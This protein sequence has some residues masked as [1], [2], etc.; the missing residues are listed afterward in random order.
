METLHTGTEQQ[1]DVHAHGHGEHHHQETFITKYVFSLDHKTIGKQFLITGMAWAIIGGLMSVI[2]RLQLG[3]PDET[4]PWLERIFSAWYTD[5]KLTPEAYYSLITMHG[6]IMVFFVLTASLSG[7]FANILIPL[8]IGARDMA[9]PLM[10][11]ISY[12]LFFISG[13]IMFASLFLPTGAA[14]A[15]WT[16]YPPLSALPQA[17]PGSGAGM[18]WWLIA[19][20]LFVAST[21]VGG[22]NYVSTVLNLRTKGMT[23]FK[24]PLTVWALFFTAIIGILSFPV[25]VSGVVLLIFDRTLHTSFYLSDIV[26]GGKAMAFAGGSP[27][28]FQHLFWFL[29]HPEV[30]III[31]PAMGMVSE[32]LAVHSRKP[33]FGYKAMIFSILGITILGFIVWAHHMFVAGVNPFLGSIFTLFTLLIAIPSAVKVFNWLTTLWKGNIKITPPLV[34]AVAFVSTFIS[35]G[36]TGIWLGN[37]TIDIQVHA[38]Y[39]VV[40]HF[41]IVMGVSAFFGMFAG[42]YHWYP[43]MFGRLMNETLAY[44]HFAIT[45]IGAYLIFWPMHFQGLAGVP[46]RYFTNSEF[47]QFAVFDDMNKL[48]SIATVIVFFAQF[49]FLI[50]FFW[51]IKRGRK[52]G[53]NPWG[54]N[55]LEWTSPIEGI[56]GN[57]EGDLPTVYRWPYDYSRPGAETDFIPQT[58]PLTEKELQEEI[59]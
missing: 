56:H 3:W 10:N 22:L 48:I 26:I 27:V 43:R 18:T 47:P 19:M 20:V 32:I 13:V 55:T 21:L 4:F 6:T 9:S 24:L 12:W 42:V 41:H 7:T 29:G 14:S 11:A 8:Q 34:F 52:S 46:R 57:W 49:I 15:G 1:V 39:F 36:L 2:F 50:N 45:F 38:T 54:A 51:S 23:M 30:Y 28:L 37:S 25:L 44:I 17:S 58:V 59:H 35:G 5:G 40:A 16:I 33:I 31:L 53:Q